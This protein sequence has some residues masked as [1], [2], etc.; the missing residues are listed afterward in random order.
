MPVIAACT[1]QQPMRLS[2]GAVARMVKRTAVAA[3]VDLDVAGRSS[4]T[5]KPV[6]QLLV[7]L[8]VKRSH[9]RPHVSNDNPYSEAQF[10]TLKYAPAFPGRFGSL[11][12]SRAF[13]EQFFS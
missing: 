12:D 10:K 1:I 11:P 8:G 6:A 3:H 7:D 5:S 4:M 9:S 13:C 2:D